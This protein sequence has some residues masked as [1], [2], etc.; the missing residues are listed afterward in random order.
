MKIHCQEETVVNTQ[1]QFPLDS[2][3]LFSLHNNI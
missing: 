1:I 3:V 2:I